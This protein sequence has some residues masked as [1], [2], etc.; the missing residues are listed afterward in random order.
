MW[1]KCFIQEAEKPYLVAERGLQSS[2]GLPHISCGTLVSL[3]PSLGLTP[4]SKEFL[5]NVSGL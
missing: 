5:T 3:P 4:P 1:Q 2:P